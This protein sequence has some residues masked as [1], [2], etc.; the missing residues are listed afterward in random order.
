MLFVWIIVIIGHA[1]RSGVKPRVELLVLLL[2]K[3]L[4]A[5]FFTRTR[6]LSLGSHSP[7]QSDAAGALVVV[8][9]KE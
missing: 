5:T 2:T 8:R 1:S 4:S 9:S 3:L 6:R 7:S